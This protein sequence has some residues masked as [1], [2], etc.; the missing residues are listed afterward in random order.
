MSV[1]LARV[2]LEDGLH[3][4]IAMAGQENAPCPGKP[5]STRVQ[6]IGVQLVA[7]KEIYVVLFAAG[8]GKSRLSRLQSR[9]NH[10]LFF[11]P[12]V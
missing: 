5:L 9:H 4:L 3:A 7:G 11:R 12:T 8:R 10:N 1:L 6:P 2:T